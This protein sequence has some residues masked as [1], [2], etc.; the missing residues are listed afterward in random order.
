MYF[1]MTTSKLSTWDT[2]STAQNPVLCLF[3]QQ[4]TRGYLCEYEWGQAGAW[5]GSVAKGESFFHMQREVETNN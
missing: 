5:V 1:M 3:P 4:R 2:K